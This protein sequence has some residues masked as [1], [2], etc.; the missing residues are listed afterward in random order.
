MSGSVTRI[1]VFLQAWLACGMVLAGDAPP[2]SP[3]G[4]AL[5]MRASQ[6]TVAIEQ[7]GFSRLFRGTVLAIQNDA[8]TV[9]TAAHFVGDTEKGAT[10]QVLLDAGTFDGIVVSVARNPA[11]QPDASTD[12]AL[13]KMPYA[14]RSIY[15]LRYAGPSRYRY[16]TRWHYHLPD[17]SGVLHRDVPAP[18]NAIVRIWFPTRSGPKER[19]V[20]V[21]FRTIRPVASL[22]PHICPEVSGGRLTART[23]DG[24]GVEHVIRAG[25]FQNPRLLEWGHAYDTKWVDI[26]GGVFTLRH[27]ADGRP[28]LTLIGV[29]LAP[30]LRGGSASLVSSSMSWVADALREGESR[31]ASDERSLL[32]PVP[33]VR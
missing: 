19:P 12:V 31:P 26:G 15:A 33:P 21:A 8:L 1:V 14:R 20:D 5:D 4:M 13:N 28:E 3:S 9:L 17:T 16:H 7:D 23:V 25:T 2:A 10:A 29:L 11:Y 30:D 32:N 22:T 24:K 27:G 18:D 6:V